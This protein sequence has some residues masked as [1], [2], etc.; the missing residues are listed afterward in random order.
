MHLAD[1]GI[2]GD[3]A[4]ASGDLAGGKSFRPELFQEIDAFV[5][6]GHCICAPQRWAL[7]ADDPDR[8]GAR[9]SGGYSGKTCNEHTPSVSGAA[10]TRN[11]NK[12]DD[13][14]GTRGGPRL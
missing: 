12:T 4:E 10:A 1:D 6:P 7:R 5:V 9:E 11:A 3:A 13:D 2:A 14:A 8:Q